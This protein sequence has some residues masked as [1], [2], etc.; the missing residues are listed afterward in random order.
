MLGKFWI[1]I[2]SSFVFVSPAFAEKI[3]LALLSQLKPLL[4]APT[5]K[6]ENNKII[7][8]DLWASWCEPCKESLPHYAK[9]KKTYSPQGVLFVV[10][11]LDG[12]ESDSLNFARQLNLNL[13][14]YWDTEKKLQKQLQIQ[15]VPMLYLLNS[16][17]EILY[18]SRGYDSKELVQLESE[19]KK[20]IKANL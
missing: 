12:K 10:V 17:G 13:N 9:L 20:H 5:V 6:V 7:F 3:D 16:R 2:F 14:F 4:E 8:L 18:S 1:V 19:L 11:G 15:A